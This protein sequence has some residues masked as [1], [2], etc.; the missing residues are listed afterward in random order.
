MLNRLA[1]PN[2][3]IKEH[4][5]DLL[6]CLEVLKNMGYIRSEHLY[7]LIKCACIYH[8]YGKVN[9]KFQIRVKSDK[10]IKF[11]D[12]DEVAHNVLSMFFVNPDD[13]DKGTDDYYKVLFAVG[14][15]HN[16][17]CVKE[18]LYNKRELIKELL[19]P[20]DTFAIKRS[21]YNKIDEE[22]MLNDEAVLLK[23]FL[24]KCDYCASSDCQVELKNDYLNDCM[25]KLLLKWKET[26]PN[27]DWKPMQK[28]C[29]DNTDNNI[30]VVAQTGMGKTEGA[31]KWIGNNKGYF[32]LP[33]RTAINAMYDRI[34]NNI[35][36]D[37]IEERLGIL[38]SESI[39]YIIENEYEID[40]VVSYNEKGKKMSMPLTISTIDQ[41]FDFV[42]R[43]NGYEM[44]LTT[45]SYSKIVVDEIQMYGPELLAYLIYGIK[46]II[47][48][49]GKV[50]IVTATLPPFI[51]ELLGD[52]FKYAE[53]TDDL[54][55]H[56]IE[57]RNFRINDDEIVNKYYDN[58]KMNKSNKIL[59]IC[60]TIKE[61]QRM[62]D[63][64]VEKLL[65]EDK[66]NVNM[67]HTRFTKA[68][69]AKKEFEIIEV[70][71]TEYEGNQIWITT[72]VVE[73]SLDIDFDYL[74]T[75]LMDINSLFQR[76]GRC[77]RKG[78][79][80]C[81]ETNCYVYTEIDE[82]L[83]SIN[84]KGFIDS[85]IFKISK[86]AISTVYGK[87]SE[88]EKIELINKYFTTDKIADSKFMKDYKKYY[89]NV[90]KLSLYSMDKRD[91]ELR[92]IDSINIVP[93]ILYEKNVERYNKLKNA[94]DNEKDRIEKI[95]LIN[96][97]CKDMISV[98]AYECSK[99]VNANY[100]YGTIN[101]RRYFVVIDCGY[102]S[103]KG[104]VSKSKSSDNGYCTFW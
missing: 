48:M 38:H 41:L 62:Y 80:S 89:K 70:G 25:D 28:Y 82:N 96:E 93:N 51:R 43:Y 79:K 94:I 37:N 61:A 2:K 27:S 102:D 92:H 57:V 12:S 85:E 35:V 26:N 13:F 17:C 20:F 101:G 99:N 77:N 72:S 10:W 19:K 22:L 50:A 31:L 34:V 91:V 65:P 69:R 40:D 21:I 83:L 87:I 32:V 3:T 46:S 53:F 42:F 104:F 11:N 29:Q 59:V 88:K 64:V 15:H 47:K 30:I 49:G 39:D 52:K 98:P 23:G 9:E 6:N 7:S 103:K 84:G 14:Y 100:N 68:D 18:T 54:L 8:D 1:K 16:Y 24:H 74:F 44:K 75:E 76:M 90:K 67:L 60:N 81:E 33:L 86:E 55:R 5:Q 78:K 4:T 58:K 36:I 71:R 63:A 56:N 45:F 73:A 95:K 66:D 97:F